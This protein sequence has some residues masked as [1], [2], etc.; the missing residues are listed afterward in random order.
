MPV[1]QIMNSFFNCFFCENILYLVGK[2]GSIY[3]FFFLFME[4]SV[5]G[6]NS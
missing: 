4:K 2:Y 6:E 5:L 1:V 3:G